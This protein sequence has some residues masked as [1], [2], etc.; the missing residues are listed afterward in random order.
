[1][2]SRFVKFLKKNKD[3]Q[4]YLVPLIITLLSYLS[5]RPCRGMFCIFAGRGIPLP[6]F[7]GEWNGLAFLFDFIFWGILYIVIRLIIWLFKIV[8]KKIT[9]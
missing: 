4:Y 7:N 2:K 8:I 5:Y 1:M 3:W 9:S 6:Y